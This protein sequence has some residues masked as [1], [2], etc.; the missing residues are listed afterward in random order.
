MLSLKENFSKC[1]PVLIPLFTANV[2]IT[3]KMNVQISII[4]RILTSLN[5]N[6]IPAIT[7]ETRYL[8]LP[9]RL[10]RPLAFENYEQMLERGEISYKEFTA[11]KKELEK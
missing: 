3:V 11:K 1:S 8:A 7:G 9:A 10:T 6:K 2:E 4:N 5:D